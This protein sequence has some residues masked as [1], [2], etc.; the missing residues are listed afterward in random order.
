MIDPITTLSFSIYS[1]PDVYAVLLGSGISRD[2]R[3]PTGWEIV[4][5]LCRR[6]A[7]AQGNFEEESPAEW[8]EK[9]Y[10]HAPKYDALLELL[11]KT[12]DERQA[13]LQS[14]FIPT[15]SE[16]EEGIKLPTP[17]HRA[18][19]SLVKLGFI[20]I[21]LTTN[22]DRLMETALQD[23]GVDFDVASSPEAIRG[24]R[25]FVHTRCTIYKLHGDFKDPRI[26]NT[27]DELANYSQ[28]QN[29]LLDRVLDEFGLIIVG[30]SGEWDVALRAAMLRTVSRRYSWYWLAVGSVRDGAKELIAHRRAEVINIEGASS[31]IT[32]LCTRVEGMNVS[33][34]IHPY[35]TDAVVGMVKQF[36]RRGD[37]IKLEEYF[38]SESN[39]LREKMLMLPQYGNAEDFKQNLQTLTSISTPLV[40]SLLTLSYYSRNDE[41]LFPIY[42]KT[43]RRL[44]TIPAAGGSVIIL[45]LLKYPA[46][47]CMYAAGISAVVQQN[48]SL[49]RN[50]LI[51]PIVDR[52]RQRTDFFI[53]QISTRSVFPAP[54][55]IPR[56]NANEYTAANNHL[57]DVLKPLFSHILPTNEEFAD[58]F[59][60]F[61][62]LSSLF[63]TIEDRRR[64]GT[65]SFI[66]GRFGWDDDAT[67]MINHFF[68]DGSKENL[69]WPVLTQFFKLTVD[70]FKEHLTLYEQ[71]FERAT[72]SWG[73]E[74]L[75][76][77]QHYQG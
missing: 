25:P 38:I 74:S 26:L 48:Y 32:Q 60:I 68:H 11:C 8:Y 49:L 19:A 57:Y 39:A 58:A 62:I 33:N 75:N 5:D 71:L 55:N 34:T 40:A 16:M 56:P 29:Q 43:V 45:Q 53:K 21:I 10:G 35:T 76:L 2:A 41:R 59:N 14:Y 18:L 22:F 1:N 66:A 37:W 46:L 12:P 61:E 13:L 65:D 23:E 64:T 17:A 63:Y 50:I 67:Q 3:I 31:F 73:Y 70:E 6:I 4:L 28:E 47:L 44:T 30:W 77:S 36:L 20:R 54:L 52:H 69:E 15:E 72:A 51:M 24:N 42:E 7:A 27:P 9:L